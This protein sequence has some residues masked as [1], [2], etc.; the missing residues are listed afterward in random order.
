MG[1]KKSWC[2]SGI[3]LFWTEKNKPIHAPE[4]FALCIVAPGLTKKNQNR[5]NG[6]G[7]RESTHQ[8]PHSSVTRHKHHLTFAPARV[9][10]G[11]TWSTFFLAR[12]TT[13]SNQNSTMQFITRL[14]LN[15]LSPWHS[16]LLSVS[17]GGSV[18]YSYIVSPLV[19][20][21]LPRQQFS[22]L[23]SVV[24][25]TYFAGQILSPLLL[26]LTSPMKSCPFHLLILALSALGGLVNYLWLLPKCAA[27][28]EA[29]NATKEDSEEHK[30][31]SKQFGMYHG[32]STLANTVSIAALGYYSLLLHK[33]LV[34]PAIVHP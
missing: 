18:F 3:R 26:A 27:I 14:G 30:E 7:T 29:R 11:A 10:G 2:G 4:E 16:L 17:F 23:Q 25:P 22:E 9:G 13:L 34:S 33:R 12:I 28:K 6:L 15:T 32:L 19:F 5:V 1:P 24:F 8:P 20:K 31:L 21:K